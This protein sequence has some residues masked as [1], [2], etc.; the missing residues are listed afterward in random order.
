MINHLDPSVIRNF[1]NA[2]NGNDFFVLNTYKN[3]EGKNKWSI[4]CSAMDWIEVAVGGIPYIELNHSNANISSLNFMQL[5]CAMDLVKE[6]IDQLY[7]VFSIPY[8]YKDDFSVFMQ[9]INDDSFF[10]HIRAVFGTHPVNLKGL[11]NEDNAKY[12]ASWSSAKI[13]DDFSVVMYSNKVGK[14]SYIFSVKIDDLFVYITKRYNLL[15]QIRNFINK[16]Y[17]RH[18]NA[19]LKIPIAVCSDIEDYIDMLIK[20]NTKR[21]GSSDAYSYEL[22]IIKRLLQTSLCDFAIAE[23][24][25]EYLRELKLVLDE[26]MSNLQNMKIENLKTDY[27]INPKIN[28]EYR[29]DYSKVFDYIHTPD[30][31][32]VHYLKA[33]FSIKMLIDAQEIPEYA[34]KLTKEELLLLINTL[35]FYRNEE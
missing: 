14:E 22:F 11:S 3:H 18:V 4:I 33:E 26:I 27:I 9:E 32:Y 31:D 10:K 35:N 2:V 34:S 28:K 7:R 15:N 25:N 13:K 29:Y 12:Y 19:L 6:S 21:F 20:E 23:K 30:S 1:R 8:P 24:A 17:K 5:I 16:E